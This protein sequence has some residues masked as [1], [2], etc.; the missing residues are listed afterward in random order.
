[1]TSDQ[2]RDWRKRL[3]MSQRKAAEI[4]GLHYRTI[5]GY[6]AGNFDVPRVVELAC[7]ALEAEK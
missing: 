2:L 6:E 1:M 4:L 5:Q 3:A 7:K